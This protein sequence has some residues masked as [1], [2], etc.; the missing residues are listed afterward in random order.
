[1]MSHQGYAAPG[2]ARGWLLGLLLTTF[3]IGTDDFVVAG[4]LPSLSADL[5][6]SLAAAGQL[7]T[8]FSLTYAVSAPV[9][10]VAT[11][12]LG[13]RS[14]VVSGLVAFAIINLLTAAVSS[15]AVLLVLRMLAALVASA[16]SPAAFAAASALAAPHRV[17]RAIGTVAAGLTVS[18]VMGVPIGSRLS[19]VLD[20]R[21]TFVA[22]ALFTCVAVA[23]TALTLPKHL[24]TTVV[25]VRRRLVLLRRPAVV[26]CVTGTVIGACGGLMTYTYVAP[27]T[28]GLTGAGDRYLV[29]FIVVIGV[30]GAVGTVVGGRL[31]DRWG[32]DRTVVVTLATL[33]ADTAALAAIGHL[34]SGAPAWLIGVLL[35]VWGL[36][37]WGHNP[38]MNARVLRIAA[39]AGTEAV[40]LNTSGLYLGVALA[41]AVGGVALSRHGTSA[42]L[43]TAA[44]VGL[45][46]ILNA[47]VAV[48]RWPTLSGRVQASGPVPGRR[49]DARPDRSAR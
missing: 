3:A 17:G 20:W 15:Y 7:V 16:L 28:G 49:P 34:R 30:A 21:A 8:V 22:V 13:R 9:M 45:L 1:M 24:R 5:D 23:V 26:S 11:A 43:G 47:A 42:V 2:R 29:P 31:T 19:E 35:A 14:L 36:A 25:G 41:G 37:A 46:A 6:V 38:P 10:A 33:V 27:I 18:L 48:R 32:A 40:A 44:A 12:R 39:E 4:A